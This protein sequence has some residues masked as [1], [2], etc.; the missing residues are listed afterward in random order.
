MS[1]GLAGGVR[2]AYIEFRDAPSAETALLLSGSVFKGRPLSVVAKRV[3]VPG[4][5]A[6]G[7]GRSG[8]PFHPRGGHWP[9]PSPHLH[10]SWRG[11]GRGRGGSRGGPFR[12]QSVIF[13]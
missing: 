8:G 11:R 5:G 10:G 4:H 7:R 3:N 2:Y 9:Y 13:G 1:G 6:W 12:N